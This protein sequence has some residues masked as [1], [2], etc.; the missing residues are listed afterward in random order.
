MQAAHD[1]CRNRGEPPAARILLDA[2]VDLFDPVALRRTPHGGKPGWMLCVRSRAPRYRPQ[3]D[4]RHGGRGDDS[5]SRRVPGA[6]GRP[7]SPDGSPIRSHDP[8]RSPGWPSPRRRPLSA[9]G[10]RGHID[11]RSPA[12]R[13]VPRPVSGGPA[14]PPVPRPPL[15]LDRRA[16]PI[17]GQGKATRARSRGSASYGGSAAPH[18]QPAVPGL[19]CVASSGTRTRAG[20][21]AHPR[22]PTRNGFRR[23][24][25]PAPRNSV[26]PPAI[27]LHR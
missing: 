9:R 27:S 12:R 8:R 10:R 14:L 15:R 19:R 3:P 21:P 11:R 18:P 24:S 25:R 16:L 26:P 6:S 2:G 4:F 23:R 7:D 5:V 22:T 1:S 17:L 13:S 20:R